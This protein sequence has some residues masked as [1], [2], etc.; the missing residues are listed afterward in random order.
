MVVAVGGPLALVQVGLV[1][2]VLVGAAVVLRRRIERQ[3]GS[4]ARQVVRLTPQH[5]VHTLEIEGRVLVVGTGPSGPPSLIESWT[6]EV[7]DEQRRDEAVRGW[8]TDV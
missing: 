8:H 2:L 1:L 7:H 4:A 5:V 3:Q 6:K